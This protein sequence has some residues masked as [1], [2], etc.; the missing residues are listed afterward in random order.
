MKILITGAKGQ[1]GSELL[2]YAAAH[3]IDAVGIDIDE[4]DITNY[5]AVEA[6]F[7]DI[8]PNCI[9]HCAAYTAVDK[10]E[11]NRDL[12]LAINKIGTENIVKVCAELK[13][14]LIYISTDYVFPGMGETPYQPDD[15]T[16]PVNFYGESKLL[17]ELAV[18]E[19]L[20]DY[21]IVRISWVFGIGG[22]NFVKTMLTLADTKPELRVVGDQIGSPTYCAD[23]APLLFE[24]AKGSTYG[25]YHATNEGFCSWAEF[26]DFSI[27]AA[28]KSCPIIPITT[29]EYP[30]PAPRPKNSR[31]SKQ[32]LTNNGFSALPTWQSAV[33]RYIK[34]LENMKEL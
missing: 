22:P 5:D 16:A 8:N 11:S 32:K 25:I 21:F 19:F 2:R 10:A 20:T 3:G 31:M 6:V 9:I 27:K 33:E 7:R 26:A 18:K 14:K 1:L 23:L 13:A 30:T 4:C 34:E 24:M 29:E 17:G 12:C 28:G 15:A